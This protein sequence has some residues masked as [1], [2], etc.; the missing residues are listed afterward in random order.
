MM[1]RG[2]N[3]TAKLLL[4]FLAFGILTGCRSGRDNGETVVRQGAG[5]VT[6]VGEEDAEM[7]AAKTKARNSLDGFLAELRTPK[8]TSFYLVKAP[9]KTDG[10]STEYIWLDNL[11]FSDGKFS[12]VITDEPLDIKA[13]HKGDRVTVSRDDVI[14]WLV[15][16]NGQMR[17]GYTEEVVERRAKNQK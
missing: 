12:G 7:E 17:G 2:M 8:K 5:P 11:E 14:D 15:S 9:F 4:A 3:L 1:G 10:G 6:F 16:E 13:I